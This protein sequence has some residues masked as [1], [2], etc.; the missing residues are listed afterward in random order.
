MHGLYHTGSP[1]PSGD[2]EHGAAASSLARGKSKPKSNRE[3]DGLLEAARQ[4]GADAKSLS[5]RSMRKS[6]S[7]EKQGIGAKEGVHKAAKAG[8][9]AQVRGGRP[10]R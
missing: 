5:P 9:R 6:Q 4:M 1:L 2:A 10:L 3:L 8:G 7:R